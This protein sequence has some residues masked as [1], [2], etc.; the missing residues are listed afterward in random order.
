MSSLTND[1]LNVLLYHEDLLS[2]KGKIQSIWS[3]FVGG[4]QS[5]SPTMQLVLKATQDNIINN[6][7]LENAEF[8]TTIKRFNGLMTDIV[9]MGIDD[10][11][12][13]TFMRTLHQSL[14]DYISINDNNLTN[15]KINTSVD[16]FNGFCDDD[17]KILYALL[18]NSLID[19][20]EVQ[21]LLDNQSLELSTFANGLIARCERDGSRENIGR[22]TTITSPLTLED[23]G[24][25]IV[26]IL[27]WV[28]NFISEGEDLF[29]NSS[30]DVFKMIFPKDD[31]DSQVLYSQVNYIPNLAN[32]GIISTTL[33]YIEDSYEVDDETAVFILSSL[34]EQLKCF[35]EKFD[36]TVCLIMYMATVMVLIERIIE[37]DGLNDINL[38]G[39]LKK[40]LVNAFSF[41][42]NG[43]TSETSL[44]NMV[45][46]PEELKDFVNKSG[47]ELFPEKSSDDGDTKT[48]RVK[49]LNDILS[50]IEEVDETMEYYGIGDNSG[51]SVLESATVS[52]RQVEPVESKTQ[53]KQT[54]AGV[55]EEVAKK[56]H[57]D[58]N[59][60][61]LEGNFESAANQIALE[62]ALLEQLDDNQVD[63]SYTLESVKRDIATYKHSVD[64]SSNGISSYMDSAR[65]EVINLLS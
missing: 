50:S 12:Y 32:Y 8:A 34:M 44:S 30:S 36:K 23:F 54:Y 46:I 5:P 42:E 27:D 49:A 33:K 6:L 47:C 14:S 57:S 31:F 65:T 10:T 18:K 59:Q 39:S 25:D 17:P 63:G 40:E 53:V 3:D 21:G 20:N 26:K 56:F 58:L 61:L 28:K 45:R 52:S 62:V 24:T 19:P 4:E 13:I 2:E 1:S 37:S 11:S 51:V 35:I 48:N 16:V 15:S 55:V 60:S 43:K 7:Q 38:T 41:Y 9:N 64:I 22:G 29:P